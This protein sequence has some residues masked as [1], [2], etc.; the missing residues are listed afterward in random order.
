MA[1]AE[2]LRFLRL[3]KRSGMLTVTG[4][5]GVPARAGTVGPLPAVAAG[6]QGDGCLHVSAHVTAAHPGSSVCVEY[7][8]WE[9]QPAQS[10]PENRLPW[11][12]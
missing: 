2:F 9:L 1:A 10:S 12:G 8:C 5:H 6:T 4:H 3:P 11:G 7:G